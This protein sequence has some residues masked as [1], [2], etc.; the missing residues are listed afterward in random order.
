[1]PCTG[2][3]ARSF[4]PYIYDVHAVPLTHEA[5]VQWSNAHNTVTVPA[6]DGCSIC[7]LLV[8]DRRCARCTICGRA[9]E[10]AGS[11]FVVRLFVCSCLIK[12]G[13]ISR[14]RHA[15]E[16]GRA[17][18]RASGR[19]AERFGSRRHAAFANVRLRWKMS[20]MV[21]MEIE[22]NVGYS[23]G[24]VALPAMR[25]SCERRSDRSGI[26]A[27]TCCRPAPSP[28]FFHLL[29]V[30]DEEKTC[31]TTTCSATCTTSPSWRVR[32]SAR[33]PAGSPSG[34]RARRGFRRRG[35]RAARLSP[36]AVVTRPWRGGDE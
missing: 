9:G 26:V 18:A 14:R 27:L 25:E 4:V 22:L 10:R 29:Q 24:E 33:D 20:M 11:Q 31:A 7:V 17:C 30:A 28:L 3:H 19:C 34:T 32:S 2:A 5:T 21:W 12:E 13:F 35:L 36:A 1:M 8:L 16:C 23:R 6:D 15:Q